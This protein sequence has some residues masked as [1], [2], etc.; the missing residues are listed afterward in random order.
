MVLRIVGEIRCCRA[1]QFALFHAVNRLGRRRESAVTPVSDF[2]E[3]Q[4][5]TFEHDQVDLAH[6]AA[7]IFFDGFE[8]F[9]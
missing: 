5:I 8:T 1:N 9:R 7:E 3:Y 4:A 2:D 6:A